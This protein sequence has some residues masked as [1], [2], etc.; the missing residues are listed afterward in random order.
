MADRFKIVSLTEAALVDE[1]AAEYLEEIA[2]EWYT[3]LVVLDT[4]NN[5]VV[6]YEGQVE[7]ED[8]TLDRYYSALVR[9][10]NEVDAERLET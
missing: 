10:L 9:L 7:P 2:D 1:E 8:A 3:P 5:K 4:Q 6:F